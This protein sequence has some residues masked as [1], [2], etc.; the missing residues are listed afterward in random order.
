MAVAFGKQIVCLDLFDKPSTCQKVWDRLLSGGLLDAQGELDCFGRS[1]VL[2]NP[3][4][5]LSAGHLQLLSI[6]PT[7][8][9][10]TPSLIE[11]SIEPQ[12]PGSK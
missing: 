7:L 2:S 9:S 3:R 1:A 11:T 8:L 10:I 12:Y 4:E 6:R 5:V